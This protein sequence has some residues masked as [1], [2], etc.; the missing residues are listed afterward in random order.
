MPRRG[1]MVLRW[2]RAKNRR[3]IVEALE[4]AKDQQEQRQL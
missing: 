1:Q 2:D 3:K 4:H